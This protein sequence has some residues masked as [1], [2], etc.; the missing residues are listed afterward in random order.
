M[1]VVFYWKTIQEKVR[2]ACLLLSMLTV[3]VGM[4][5][6]FEVFCLSV[7]LFVCSITKNRA[8]PN[9]IFTIRP[10]TE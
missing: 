3:L 10:N 4:G 9:S 1:S 5:R 2:L 6:M 8:A 7:C